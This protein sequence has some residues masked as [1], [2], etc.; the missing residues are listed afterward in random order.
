MIRIFWLKKFFSFG[1]V[2]IWQ[3]RVPFV[4]EQEE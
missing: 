1:V 4:F 2:H 3:Q